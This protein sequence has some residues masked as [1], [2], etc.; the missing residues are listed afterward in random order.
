MRE[1]REAELSLERG[2]IDIAQG[3][4]VVL[5]DGMDTS[6]WK[7]CSAAGGC[8]RESLGR[9]WA[10]GT[11]ALI[12]L[13]LVCRG[14]GRGRRGSCLGH[15]AGRG[16]LHRYVC[17]CISRRGERSEGRLPCRGASRAGSAGG[18]QC[19][20]SSVAAHGHGHGHGHRASQPPTLGGCKRLFRIGQQQTSHWSSG[21]C[22]RSHL[23]DADNDSA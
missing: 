8:Y 2:E 13:Y 7:D 12:S 3:R 4:R 20:V 6:D 17:A 22:A 10:L 21:F 1:I 23:C 14:I 11:A 19:P 9:A 5:K 16:S 15:L 18:V